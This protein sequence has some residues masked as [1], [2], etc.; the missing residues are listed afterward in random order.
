MVFTGL[1]ELLFGGTI[2]Y[3]NETT[4]HYELA[5]FNDF[6]SGMC[7]CWFLLIINNWNVIAYNYA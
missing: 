1:G 5:N 2:N 6:L 3:S 7:T 4:N